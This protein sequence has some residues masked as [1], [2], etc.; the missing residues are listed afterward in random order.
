MQLRHLADG[1]RH[2]HPRRRPPPVPLEAGPS[3]HRT[4][5]GSPRLSA[6]SSCLARSPPTPGWSSSARRRRRELFQ[7]WLRGRRPLAFSLS[8]V[9]LSGVPGSA[10]WHLVSRGQDG[11]TSKRRPRIARLVGLHQASTYTR[12]TGAA[13]WDTGSDGLVCRLQPVTAVSPP[14][15][16]RTC[17]GGNTLV[18]QQIRNAWRQARR[19]S[20]CV[21]LRQLQ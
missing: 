2:D 9:H 20:P 15:D 21:P 12:H 6:R 5:R 11:H 18:T 17:S 13:G 8:Q 4:G 14:V 19:P 7:P 16:P 3:R 1:R 10:S